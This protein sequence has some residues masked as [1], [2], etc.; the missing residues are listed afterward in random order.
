VPDPQPDA[1]ATIT[2]AVIP[3]S[4][5]IVATQ[6]SI[7]HGIT[8]WLA[9]RGTRL[10]AVLHVGDVVN[11]GSRDP[12]QFAVAAK[13]HAAILDAGIP[14]AVAAGNH[15]YD[16][17]L[18]A[19]RSL[20]MFNDQIGFG[21]LSAQPGFAGSFADSASE[22]SVLTLDRPT[23]RIVV[24]T[25]E[26]GPRREVLDWADQVLAEH[27]G[28]DVVVLTHSYLDSDAERTNVGSRY[29][30]RAFPGSTD[31]LDGGQVWNSWLSRR[32]DVVAVF[33]G[34]Q[35]PGLLAHRVD[36]SQTGTEVL[37]T[38]QNWQSAPVNQQSCIRLVRWTPA[39]NAVSLG[40]VDTRTG[41]LRHDTGFDTRVALSRPT[42]SR[43][44]AS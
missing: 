42:L 23:G 28:S 26:F 32:S 5:I 18:D 24:L 17:E 25:L 35:M 4:Q 15:D 2:L 1:D 36:A 12:E 22:N 13:A 44:T 34:H 41:R 27:A 20:D 29:H 16:D 3:D 31:A 21:P 37:Q 39:T 33:S 14:L 43:P 11:Q 7:Y 19:T 30:P 9:E 6:P 10:D 40:V 8:R 38:F